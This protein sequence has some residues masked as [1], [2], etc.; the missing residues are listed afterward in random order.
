M[1]EQIVEEKKIDLDSFFKRLDSV[2]KVADGA[3]FKS[4]SNLGIINEQKSLIENISMSIEA[5]KGEIKEITNYIIVE[6]KEAKDKEEDRRLEDEDKEQ[7]QK[8]TERALGLGGAGGVAAGGGAT[9]EKNVGEFGK[10]PVQK[11]GIFGTLKNLFPVLGAGILNVGAGLAKSI[12]GI[13]KG[14]GAVAKGIGSI[15]AGVG[16][17]IGK[18]IGSLGAGIGAGVGKLFKK[19]AESTVPEEGDTIMS[20]KGMFGP[21]SEDKENFINKF[22]NRKKKEIKEEIKEEIDVVDTKKGE[23]QGV[24]P[25]KPE[26]QRDEVTTDKTIKSDLS[27]EKVTDK[28]EVSSEKPKGRKIS[29]ETILKLTEQYKALVEKRKANKGLTRREDFDRRKLEIILRDIGVETRDI[30]IEGGA[31]IEDLNNVINKLNPNAEEAPRFGDVGGMI[32]FDNKDNNIMPSAMSPISDEDLARERELSKEGSE[33]VSSVT[34]TLKDKLLKFTGG[35]K[36]LTESPTAKKLKEM[37]DNDTLGLEEF[38]KKTSESMGGMEG[39]KNLKDNIF[40]TVGGKMS[41]GLDSILEKAETSFEVLGQIVPSTLESTEASQQKPPPQP[42]KP[43]KSGNTSALVPQN[44]PNVT[45]VPIRQ[46][47]S[48]IPFVNMTRFQSSEFNNIKRLKE[49]EL[50][51]AVR[52]LLKIK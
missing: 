48:D 47:T 19:S 23:V 15:G 50:P 2:E 8:M 52:N 24:E 4:E 20:G 37:G 43:P 25:S 51:A 42:T 17:G 16:K 49:T 32:K 13:G 6:K 28:K 40:S 34:D 44:R 41:G 10:D 29:K 31:T 3:S 1:D 38:A 21:E 26:R 33:P 39:L 45:S 30:T 36:G 5:M 14:I 46:A 7:K 27:E 18:G 22:F 35:L 11:T 12:G 9:P